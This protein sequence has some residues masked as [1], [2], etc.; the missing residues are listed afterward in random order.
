MRERIGLFLGMR[1]R[2]RCVLAAHK[3]R[4]VCVKRKFRLQSRAPLKD[5]I[6]VPVKWHPKVETI[7]KQSFKQP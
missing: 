4:I 7:F 3:R 6:R 5:F 1:R 2:I